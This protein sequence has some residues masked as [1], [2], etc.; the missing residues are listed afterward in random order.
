MWRVYCVSDVLMILDE[1]GGEG[2]IATCSRFQQMIALQQQEAD[3]SAEALLFQP[4]AWRTTRSELLTYFLSY[5][6][7]SGL[8]SPFV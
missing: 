2:K 7:L 6:P 8:T 5:D 3:T 4:S 1:V